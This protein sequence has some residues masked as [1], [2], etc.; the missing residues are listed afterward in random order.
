MLQEENVERLKIKKQNLDNLFFTADLHFGHA[1]IIKYT[2]RPWKT[3]GEMDAA[4]VANWNARIG[5]G[6]LVVVA[7]DFVMDSRRVCEYVEQLQGEIIYVLGDHGV[8]L[9]GKKGSECFRS[10]HHTLHLSMP[11]DYP[12]IIVNHWAMRRWPKMH[13]GSWHLFG[14][15]H[16]TMEPY[17]RSFDCGVDSFKEIYAPISYWAVRAFMLGLE[18]GEEM[19]LM[20]RALSNSD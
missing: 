8:V 4:L 17:G 20:D 19:R 7:G 9:P 2:K 1:N 10:V 12:D 13:H 14:H 3:V 15:S 11:D 5:H 18:D 16:G 6:D